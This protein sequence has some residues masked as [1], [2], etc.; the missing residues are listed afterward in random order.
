MKWNRTEYLLCGVLILKFK[1]CFLRN[2]A[3]GIVLK[4]PYFW[5]SFYHIVVL[6]VS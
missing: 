4:V 1:N 2:L 3:Q 5:T 6:K